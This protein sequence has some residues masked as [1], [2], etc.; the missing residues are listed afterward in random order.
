[1]RRFAMEQ[2][3]SETETEQAAAVETL[4]RAFDVI[5]GVHPVGDQSAQSSTRDAPSA[6]ERGEGF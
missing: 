3:V 4:Y 5:H 1:M 2:I 6:G